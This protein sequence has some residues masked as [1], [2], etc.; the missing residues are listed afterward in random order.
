MRDPCGVVS[1]WMTKGGGDILEP[2]PFVQ[3][4]LRQL[5][6]ED[7]AQADHLLLWSPD[8]AVPLLQLIDQKRLPFDEEDYHD[9]V[10]KSVARFIERE[11]LPHVADPRLEKVPMQ[12]REARQKGLVMYRPSDRKFITIWDT[13]A[14]IP[15][16][17]PDD[18]REEAMRVQRRYVPTLAAWRND[19]KA[20]HK[21]VL[22]VPNFA[23]G[24]LHEGMRA[25]F[26]RFNKIILKSGRFPEIKGALVVLE[27]PLGETRDWNV[28][29]NVILM[30]DG[31]LEYQKLRDLWLWTF[32]ARRIRGDS[33]EDI[34]KELR[35]I[36][37]YPVQAM[38][39]KSAE[40]AAGG[41]RAPALLDWTG[42]EFYEWWSAHQ[43]FRRTRSYGLLYGLDKPEP[44]SLEGFR[45]V[46]QVWH[47]GDRRRRSLTLL[48]SIPG[49]KSSG[50]TWVERYRR[51]IQRLL[52]PPDEARAC[53]ELADQARAAWQEL[54][55]HLQ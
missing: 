16:L 38:P 8:E 29:L 4:G 14:G 33:V 25:I 42:G 24:K 28:H 30:C 6:R 31:F 22:T 1:R 18:A 5:D 32:N 15:L 36:I 27:A 20:L 40:H 9:N 2:P 35:E 43:H 21:I 7:E 46:G 53:L 10:R 52:G 23:P 13:K 48:N 3:A 34:E 12:L 26:K 44:E 49:D 41:S 45:A 47:D 17:C 39:S 19:G 54:R 50:E 37:K 55:N 11:V 51:A